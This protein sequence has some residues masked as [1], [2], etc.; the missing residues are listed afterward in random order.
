[1]FVHPSIQKYQASEN[2]FKK[3]KIRYCEAS[4]E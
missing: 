1:M 3:K 4:Q 2:I